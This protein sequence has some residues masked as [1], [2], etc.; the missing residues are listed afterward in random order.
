M[1]YYLNGRLLTATGHL[2]VPDG[3]KL[4]EV[5]GEKLNLKQLY[6]KFRGTGSN[7]LVSASFLCGQVHFFGAND[8]VAKNILTEIY[9]NEMLRS[10]SSK[11]NS[12]IS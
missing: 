7:G 10:L 1:F 4:E 3:E 8:Q 2:F 9:K 12:G 11:D 5:E 6:A